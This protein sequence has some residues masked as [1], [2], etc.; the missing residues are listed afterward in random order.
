MEYINKMNK[1]PKII[2]YIWIG[3]EIPLKVRAVIESNQKFFSDYDV[4]IWTEDNI[5][6]LNDFAQRAFNEKK[7]AFVSDYL[8]FVI[9][10][11]YGGIYLDTDM[12]VLKPLDDLLENSFFSGWD[13]TGKYVYAGI[14]GANPNNKYINDIVEKYNNITVS[15]YPTSPKIMT[16]CYDKHN[17]KES[18]IILE[19][20]YFYPLLDGEKVTQKSLE[21]AYTNHL[22]HE[23]WR[24]YVWLRRL[25]RRIGLMKIYHRLRGVL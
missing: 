22:W 9:L 19:S 24:K 1:I 23:S 20:K 6:S 3:G 16:N 10:K 8:R 13:R 12:E 14:I 21:F 5:P 11:E 17:E 7:W 15:L 18:L 25:L 4:K 2:H